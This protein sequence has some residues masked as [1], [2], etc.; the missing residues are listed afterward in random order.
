MKRVLHIGLSTELG[1]IESFVIN[2]YRAIDK[3]KIQFD[4]INTFEKPLAYEDEIV[5]MGG[6]VFRVTTYHDSIAKYKRELMEI[7]KGYD[8]VHIH[9]LSAANILPLKI[10]KKC[11]VKKIIAHSHS[12]KAVGIIRTV[13]DYIFRPQIKNN[14]DLFLACS[15]KAGDWMFGRKVGFKVIRNAIVLEK[16]EFNHLNREDIRN[17]LS[18]GDD[19]IVY[20]TVGHLDIDKNQ[21]FL[22]DVFAE[23]MK[24]QPNSH[25]V[26][27]GDGPLK[28]Q[29]NNQIREYNLSRRVHM[30]GRRFDVNR[31]YSALDSFIL[32]SLLEGLPFTLVEAQANGLK[33]FASK[34]CVP[35]ESKMIDSMEFISLSAPPKDWARIIVE[36]KKDRDPN[37]CKE[38]TGRHFNIKEETR[39]LVDVYMN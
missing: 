27:V 3:S 36:S 11:G 20:G 5:H 4:F 34:D 12:T 13:L 32:P 9:M 23:I 39:L 26:I 8:V 29:L 22:I 37:S 38:L 33:C 6:K 2:Y 25:L 15:E 16:F 17:E 31:I 24:I 21:V 18:I 35:E 7:V 14:A 10:A 1:G 19:E 28:D 30:M